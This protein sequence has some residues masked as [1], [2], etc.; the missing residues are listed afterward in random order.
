ML[1]IILNVCLQPASTKKATESKRYGFGGQTDTSD[2]GSMHQLLG[3]LHALENCALLG[4]C[5]LS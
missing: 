2:H 1:R 3:Q 4:I 5:L